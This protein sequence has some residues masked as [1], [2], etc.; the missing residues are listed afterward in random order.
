LGNTPFEREQAYTGLEWQGMT[1]AEALSLG[2][3][4]GRPML[5]DEEWAVLPEP[6]RVVWQRRPRGRPRKA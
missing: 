6:E 5:T 1:F 3:S 2:L 4:Q